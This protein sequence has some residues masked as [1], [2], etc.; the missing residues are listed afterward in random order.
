MSYHKILIYISESNDFPLTSGIFSE[1]G[2]LGAIN[3]IHKTAN[4]YRSWE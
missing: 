3:F 2:I 1:W 4:D